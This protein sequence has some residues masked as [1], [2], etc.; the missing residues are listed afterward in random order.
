VAAPGRFSKKPINALA[1]PLFEMFF[2]H[3]GC[4][5]GWREKSLNFI[6]DA[7]GDGSENQ[8]A[9]FLGPSGGS[10][11]FEAELFAQFCRDDNLTL[12]ADDGAEGGHAF[13]LPWCKTDIKLSYR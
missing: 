9:A 3:R 5:G 1:F 10:A 8:P 11:L 12:G 7:F 6:Q 2:E 13:I 4:A